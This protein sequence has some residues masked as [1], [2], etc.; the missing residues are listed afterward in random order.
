MQISGEL[1]S[2]KGNQ[3]PDVGIIVK[4]PVLLYGVND[5]NVQDLIHCKSFGFY[6]ERDGKPLR[7]LSQKIS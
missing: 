2:R 6:P 7:I 4:R 3:C 1:H 5:E